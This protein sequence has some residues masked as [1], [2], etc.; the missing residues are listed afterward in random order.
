MV[1]RGRGILMVEM[2]HGVVVCLDVGDKGGAARD[3]QGI[4]RIRCKEVGDHKWLAVFE[5]YGLLVQVPVRC[6][7]S[8]IGLKLRLSLAWRNKHHGNLGF[9]KD[10]EPC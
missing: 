2:R 10:E 6:S 1:G 5:G 4:R 7:R 8:T 9:I 3:G